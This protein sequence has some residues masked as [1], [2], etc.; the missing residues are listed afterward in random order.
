M[1]QLEEQNGSIERNV[2]LLNE[3]FAILQEKSMSELLTCV[4]DIIRIYFDTYT[5]GTGVAD[6]ATFI[7]FCRDFD[8]FPELCSKM[9]L[10]S[11]FYALA[12]VNSRVIDDPEPSASILHSP[13]SSGRKKMERKTKSGAKVREYLDLPLFVEALALCAFQSK[14]FE[15]DSDHIEKV[16]H[17][18]QKL[19][20]S[21]GVYIAKKMI[22]NT[23]IAPGDN[24]PLY[25]LRVRYG[26][27]FE[28]KSISTHTEDVVAEAFSEEEQQVE[29]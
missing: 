17:L 5:E 23:R 27:L 22:G 7:K 16:V 8:M 12:F 14:A 3:M 10:H 11:T 6:Y 18:M 29:P 25:E 19:M 21:P 2:E 4:Q 15:R 26:E 24:D 9:I 1:Q 20:Q 13:R 28:K